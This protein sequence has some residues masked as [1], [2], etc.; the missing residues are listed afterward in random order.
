M[1]SRR[2]QRGGTVI[3]ELYFQPNFKVNNYSVPLE[4]VRSQNQKYNDTKRIFY[5]YSILGLS[6]HGYYPLFAH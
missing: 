6:K 2:T 4:L 3:Q 5:N 1:I